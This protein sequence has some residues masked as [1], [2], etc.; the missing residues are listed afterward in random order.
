MRRDGHPLTVVT[1]NI[2][3]A[4][5]PGPFPDA[6]WRRVDRA[7]L[8]RIGRL[9]A[10][11]RPDVVALQEVALMTVDG[12]VH[13]QSAELARLTGLEVRYGAVGHFPIV[14]PDS[15]EKIGAAFWGNAVLSRAPVLAS[16]TIAL[17][18]AGD[19]DLVEP[20]E[21][22]LRLA[23]VRYADAPIG[24][25]E[26]RCVL[27][28][29]L[30]FDG[31]RVHALSTH[32]THVGSGQ[33]RLQ[34]QRIGDAIAALSGPVLLLGDLNAGIESPELEPVRTALGAAF[35]PA[36]TRPGAPARTSCGQVAIDHVLVRDLPP[37]SCRVAR[38][39]GEL[40]DHWPVVAAVEA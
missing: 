18:V 13:D 17:P 35:D 37:R 1:Y 5:G 34:A 27:A 11:L 29:E 26:P 9:I 31:G 15:R 38:E 25:R 28:C 7:R 30:A 3:A 36:G 16:R 21:S 40:S 2:R 32:L 22:A 39:A 19:D 12:V 24:A 14:D 20:A 23:G 8:E 4:I 33:R 6:W 10:D